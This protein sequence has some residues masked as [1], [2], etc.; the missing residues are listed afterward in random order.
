MNAVEKLLKI[1]AGQLKKNEAIVTMKLSRLNDIELDFPI[2]EVDPEYIAE[3]QEDSLELNLDGD[4]KIRSYNQKVLTIIEGCP[5]VFKNE[6]IQKRFKCNTPKE[7][8]K[9]L[10]PSGEMDYLYNEINKLNGY[11]N[12]KKE[13]EE[14]KN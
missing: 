7:L 11:K 13:K 1:D 9:E 3:L 8:V 14:V 5:L 10:L 2:M 12:A 4:V 6:A